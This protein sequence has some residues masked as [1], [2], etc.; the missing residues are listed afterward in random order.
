MTDVNKPWGW[1]YSLDAAGCNEN[2]KSYDAIK[3]FIEALVP[4]IDM[5]AFEAPRIVHFAAD[6]PIKGGYTLDQLIETSNICCHYCD[7]TG[8]AYL[9]IFSCKD[10]NEL[11]ALDVFIEYFDPQDWNSRFFRRGAPKLPH[12]DP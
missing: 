12:M 7:A 10:F 6:D 4:A 3:A 8:E 11:D 1:H 5:K 9:D 2:I